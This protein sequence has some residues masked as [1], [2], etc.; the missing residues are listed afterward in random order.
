MERVATK[1]TAISNDSDDTEGPG[2]GDSGEESKQVKATAEVL[3]LSTLVKALRCRRSWF[4]TKLKDQASVVPIVD[5][6]ATLLMEQ[7]V[8]KQ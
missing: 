7:V 2:D 8:T 1:S 4:T 5:A 3:L 6:T